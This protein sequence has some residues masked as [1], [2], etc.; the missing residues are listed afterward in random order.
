M[1][2]THHDPMFSS[3]VLM[4]L[5]IM[6]IFRTLGLRSFS[7]IAIAM[8]SKTMFYDLDSSTAK[9]RPVRALDKVMPI[10]AGPILF[11]YLLIFNKI[12]SQI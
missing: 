5:K 8:N 2:F 11:F 12:I 3:S 6:N 9:L 4:L 10:F 1:T 7:F